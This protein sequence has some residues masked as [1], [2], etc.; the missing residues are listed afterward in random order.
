MSCNILGKICTRSANRI[1]L[2]ID[3]T[4]FCE[5]RWDAK[6]GAGIYETGEFV[7]PTPA[8]RTGYH[9]ECTTAGQVGVTEPRWPIAVDTTVQDGSAVWTCRAIGN[10][11]LTK[12]I[13]AA[14]W[15]G[16]GFTVEDETV[17][18]TAGR[19]LVTAFVTGEQPRGKYVVQV[20]VEF[21]DGHI[22]TFGIVVKIE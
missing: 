11:S 10:Q 15:D 21:S 16:D 14:E 7:R 6:R 9:Y 22:D 4:D 3:L 2:P 20:E 12:T 17:I 5:R 19:Q 13:D 8:N 1:P 18:S